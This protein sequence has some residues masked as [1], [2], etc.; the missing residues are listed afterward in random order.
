MVNNA[1]AY[2]KYVRKLSFVSQKVVSKSFVIIHEIKPTLT[3]DK[4]IYVRFSVLDLRKLL[5]Y[6]IHQNYI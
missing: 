2:K 4:T 5:R 3:L 6:E 1:K